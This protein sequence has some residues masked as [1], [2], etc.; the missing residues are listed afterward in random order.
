MNQKTT[1]RAGVLIP[2]FSMPSRRSWG[3]GEI[4]D[5]E[6]CCRWMK[7]AGLTVLNILPINEASLGQDSPYSA[8]SAFAIDPVYV[9]VE[10]LPDFA[11]IGGH[12]SLTDE[13]RRTV[14]WARDQRTVDWSA[15]RW[16]KSAVLAASFEHFRE[17]EWAEATPRAQAMQRYVAAHAPWLDDYALFR[18]LKDDQGP[19]PWWEWEARLRYRDPLRIEQA[20]GDLRDR[21]LYYQYVQWVADSQWSKAREAARASGVSIM[22]DLPFMV[23]RDSADVWRRQG[24]FR[25]DAEVGVPPDAFSED[26]QKWGLPVYDWSVM[27]DNGYEWVRRRAARARELYDAYRVDHV[28][29]LY[30][31]YVF[32]DDGSPARFDPAEPAE[33]L[34]HGERVMT[35]LG[36]AGRVVAE[37]LGTVPPFV[38]RSLTQLGI[39]G[40]RVMRWEKDG[41]V[42]RDPQAWPELSVAT[43][44]THDTETSAEWW[45][46]LPDDE[47]AA[48]LEIPGL[49]TRL[50]DPPRVL[51][52]A[53]RD[54][55]LATLYES[56]SELVLTPFQDLFGHRER[57]NLPG[58]VSED[59]WVYRLP[60][61]LEALAHDSDAGEL[62]ARTAELRS[63]ALEHGRLE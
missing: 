63:L 36:G 31:T 32:P 24:E 25:M 4:P 7:D 11:A 12:A 3:L 15:A 46:A 39:P 43:S 55:V 41:D 1:R 61:P 45:E 20:R 56:P 34:A 54:A 42:F 53:V 21:I 29:G 58:T 22:G 16:L 50:T 2:L 17:T 44:G 14:D 5:I 48:L 18:A 57:V 52:G 6:L 37:D 27:R 51:D 62:V 30:R 19:L 38:R 49:A 10:A 35:A 47:R 28:V 8:L 13:Q 23:A 59:N 33:Q 60:W 9:S 26:G 40:Y